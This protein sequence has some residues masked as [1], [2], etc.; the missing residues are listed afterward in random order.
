MRT[1]AEF[2]IIGHVG[3]VKQV[4]LTLRVDLAAEYGRRDET[5]EFKPNPHWNE[6]TL[7]GDRLV[8]WAKENVHKGDLV[9]VRGTLRQTSYDKDG[10]TVYGVTLAASDFDLLSSKPQA[11]S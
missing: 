3:Q 7:F 2:Q 10:R 1:F 6:V 9:H 4:G 5:G 8:G 11:P